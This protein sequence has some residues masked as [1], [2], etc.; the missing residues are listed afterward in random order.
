MTT[1]DTHKKLNI[2]MMANSMVMG[3]ATTHTITIA[4]ELKRKGHNVIVASKG[5]QL[6]EE[7]THHGIKHH[8]VLMPV[9]GSLSSVPVRN[10]YR[11]VL[12]ILANEM[13]PPPLIKMLHI[14]IL[15]VTVAQVINIIRKE[16]IDIIH[17]SQPGP[18]LIAYLASL[19]THVP[20]VVTVHSTLRLEFPPI[21]PR[22]M[23]KK[24]GR[25]VAISDEIKEHLISNCVVDEERVDVIYN[26]INLRRFRPQ[27]RRDTA[28][29]DNA[30]SP[31]RI[32]HI[33]GWG[34]T[35]KS[36]VEAVPII[37]Q[38]ISNIEMVVAGPGAT[39][40]DVCALAQE[41]N[42]QL[43][44]EAVRIYGLTK[45]VVGLINSAEV[46][47]GIGRCALEAMACGKPVVI[48]GQRKSAIGGSFAGIVSQDNISEIKKYNFS[49]RNSSE[50]TSAEKIAKAVLNLVEDEEHRRELGAWGRRIVENE[51][52]IEKIGEQIEN[53]YLKVLEAH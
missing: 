30:G 53:V 21:G 23:S 29:R 32:A 51:F 22:S 12:S 1:T 13:R 19:V 33:H 36:A 15:L 41:V 8:S 49:G 42:R 2:M 48:A 20:I 9:Y 52:D 47:I 39:N 24:F 45:D 16:K 37:A 10:H 14:K 27:T 4:T 28:V 17:S 7:L 11:Y 35:L 46:V 25:L 43:G 6:V 34:L 3:G 5:G 38:N 44:R 31:R 26:G 50:E 40:E 18:T